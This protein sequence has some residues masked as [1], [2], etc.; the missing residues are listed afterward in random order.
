[1]L[2]TQ[3]SED[4]SHLLGKVDLPPRQQSEAERDYLPDP[5]V[6][7][8]ITAE[9]A[10]RPRLIP[11]R[12]AASFDK[13]WRERFGGLTLY[14]RDASNGQW[15]YLI[16]A[17]GPT[18]VTELKLAWDYASSLDQDE[19]ATPPALY[20]SRLKETERLLSAHGK[21][22]VK[23]SLAPDDAAAR[24]AT[25]KEVQEEFD[26]SAVLVLEAPRGRKFR[27]KQIW[28]VMLCL[29]LRWG[30]MDCFH[31]QN[32]SELGDDSFF[33]VETSTPPGY[34]LPEE[35]A[36]DRLHTTDLVFGFSA[37]RCAAPARVLEA[38]IQATQYAQKRL[39]GTILDGDGNPADFDALRGD[40]QTIEDHLRELGL[41][42]GSNDA[43][44]LF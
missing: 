8:V 43:L 24:S 25:L 26:Y 36:A 3:P 27:G 18:A 16:S 13:N 4:V 2:P 20:A 32:S 15:T 31:W 10:G 33:S 38:M 5:G 17:D 37:P 6:D 14:G 11:S 9:F 12:V 30:D 41:P 42:C 44:R 29:G 40:I 28:D 22:Q 21:V 39:G 23:A 34:F 1:L 19:P 35:I 7:W